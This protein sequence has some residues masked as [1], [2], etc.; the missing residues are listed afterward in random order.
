[1]L[2]LIRLKE[3]WPAGG[4]GLRLVRGGERELQRRSL[5]QLFLLTAVNQQM[6]KE[7]TTGIQLSMKYYAE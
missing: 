5:G 3:A 2:A 1:M 4:D 7:T 6:G